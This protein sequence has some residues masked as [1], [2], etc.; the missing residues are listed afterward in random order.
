MIRKIIILI[1]LS[2]MVVPPTSKGPLLFLAPCSGLFQ[3]LS[4]SSVQQMFGRVAHSET[5]S[6]IFNSLGRFQNQGSLQKLNA[7]FLDVDESVGILDFKLNRHGR[8]FFSEL[9][10]VKPG[11]IEPHVFFLT[12]SSDREE[13][14]LK[15]LGVKQIPYGFMIHS[16]VTSRVFFLSLLDIVLNVDEKFN[17]Q[18][19]LISNQEL[20]MKLFFSLY[21]QVWQVLFPYQQIKHRSAAR[22]YEVS[23]SIE[24]VLYDEEPLRLLNIKQIYRSP[25][26]DFGQH[27]FGPDWEVSL[28]FQ[29]SAF[30]VSN[31]FW[32]RDVVEIGFGSGVNLIYALR[33]GAKRVFGSDLFATYL[34][35]AR[36]NIEYAQETNQI[37]LVKEGQVVL[38][39][40]PGF[41]NFPLADI[42]LFNTPVI[43]I[44]ER[45]SFRRFLD[46]A[47]QM[48]PDIFVPLFK[49]LIYRL[50]LTDSFAI[51]RISIM[52]SA[53][54]VEL[55]DDEKVEE[56]DF[57][58]GRVF[59]KGK[60][61]RGKLVSEKFLVQSGLKTRLLRYPGSLLGGDIHFLSYS[62]QVETSF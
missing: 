41:A 59:K 18:F 10:G 39:R 54:L 31:Q 23:P 44:P 52:E 9:M 22:I 36:W 37:M 29:E 30:M 32:G 43:K 6:S 26:L 62:E 56:V 20:A 33:Y 45:H 51:W 24:S 48:H 3:E 12:Y 25:S 11:E 1:L 40:E 57:Q 14:R 49:E 27:P 28:D 13:F 4:S 8:E 2:L 16:S 19:D 60:V 47:T 21:K 15:H 35:L 50:S 34:F 5:L 55:T 7:D 46:V 17:L 38:T 61:K 42:Y 58:T 53:G